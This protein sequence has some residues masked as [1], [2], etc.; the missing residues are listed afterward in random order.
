[1]L[2]PHPA[3][4]PPMPPPKKEKEKKIKTCLILWNPR[5]P[6]SEKVFVHVYNGQCKGE[7]SWWE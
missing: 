3:P 7:A 6:D 4:P 5:P 1:M 2:G